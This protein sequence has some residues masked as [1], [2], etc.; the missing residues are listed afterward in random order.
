MSAGSRTRQSQ[1]QARVPHSFART[2]ITSAPVRVSQNHL[3]IIGK[4]AGRFVPI[5]WNYIQIT[6]TPSP[7]PGR[8]SPMHMPAISRRHNRERTPSQA[9]SVALILC[10]RSQANTHK[11]GTHPT[12][13]R[14]FS[15]P[16][17]SHTTP[18]PTALS[19]ALVVL[20]CPPSQPAGATLSYSETQ[21]RVEPGGASRSYDQ[22]HASNFRPYYF[23]N[24]VCTIGLEHRTNIPG[25]IQ[26]IPRWDAVLMIDRQLLLKAICCAAAG[27]TTWCA[28]PSTSFPAHNLHFRPLN[29]AA[30]T[31][32]DSLCITPLL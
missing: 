14:N 12:A 25:S 23:P 9:T 30:V 17:S 26:S 20:H 8:K 4:C 29:R 13:H 24:N 3:G 19:R 7:S 32:R 2:R 6:R 11:H 18:I 31:W 5:D 16:S 10:T 21:A 1:N 22:C 27:D 15:S 28:Y